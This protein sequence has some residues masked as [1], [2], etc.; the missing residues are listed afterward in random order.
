LVH[1]ADVSIREQVSELVRAAGGVDILVNC[2]GTHGPIGPIIENNLDDWS[3]CI[4]VNLLGTL[5]TCRAVIPAMIKKGSGSIINISGGGATAPRANFSSYAVSKAAVVRLTETLAAELTGTGV[6]ASAIA[7]GLM[8]TSLHDSVL[9][10]GQR[11][12]EHY[13]V[14]Q[15]MRDTGRGATPPE[16]PAELALFLASDASDGLSGKVIS[17]VHDSWRTWDRGFIERLTASA[18]YTM[19]RLDPF[20]IRRLG[21]HP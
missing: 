2:A 12:G 5:Y 21:A 10:A 8:N 7:P 20:T 6:R 15:T 14:V 11:A 19:R 4:S 18:W 9:A 17:A 1:A 16:I 13:R 3:Y